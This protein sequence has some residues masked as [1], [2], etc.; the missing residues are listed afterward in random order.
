VYASRFCWD[1][2]RFVQH[3]LFYI[4]RIHR[5]LYIIFGYHFS[6]Y[7]FEEINEEVDVYRIV[8]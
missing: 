6:L 8:M 4:R 7:H 5:G 1:L 3:G 2:W